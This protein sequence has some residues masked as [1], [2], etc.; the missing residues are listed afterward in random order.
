M[1]MLPKDKVYEKKSNEPEAETEKRGDANM[2]ELKKKLTSIPGLD[3]NTALCY[4]GGE[5]AIL[6]EITADVA[7]EAPVRAER[8]RKNLA[9][10]DI[11]AYGIDAHTVKSTMATMGLK[12]L[13]ERAKKHEFAAKGDDTEFIFGDAENFL[14]EY[15]EV[16]KKMM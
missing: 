5:E 9:A 6:A 2:S 15:E 12:A 11:K 14:N 3:F 13:S 4:C 8:M 1:N 10:K 16:C 7:K